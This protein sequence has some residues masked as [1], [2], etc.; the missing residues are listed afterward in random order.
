MKKSPKY[1]LALDLGTTSIGWAI[2]RLNNDTPPKPTAIIRSGVRI[3]TD[4][5]N[6]KDGSSLAVSR[7]DA[8]ST[9]RRRDRL[10]R[11]K[12][13]MMN[14]LIEYGFFPSD[15]LARK[16]Y[17]KLNPYQL[18]A[19]GLHRELSPAEFARAIFHL[20]QRRGFKSNRKTDSKDTESGVMKIAMTQTQQDI[21]ASGCTTAGEWL[22]QR[23]KKGEPT[24]ARYRVTKSKTATGKTTSHKA[25]DLYIDRQMIEDEFDALWQ[26]QSQYNPNLYSNKA[27]KDIKDTLLFQRPLKPVKAGRCTFI[28]EKE[29]APLALPSNQ[30]FRIYQEVNN[31]KIIHENYTEQPLTHE[32][33]DVIALELCRKPKLTFIGIN[34]LLNLPSNTH[35]NLQDE[36][37][38]ELKGNTTA[39]TL[40]KKEYFGL[41]WHN[42]TLEKQDE[43][44]SKLLEEESE[45]KLIEWLQ[46]HTDVDEKTASQIANVRLVDGYGSL[47]SEALGKILYALKTQYCVYSDAVQSAG[48]EH[49]SKLGFHYNP[50]EVED[51][52]DTSTGEIK[53]IFKSLPYYGKALNRYVAFGSGKSEDSDEKRYGKIAN[54]T[55]HIALNQ[56]QKLVNA[57]IKEYGRP[58]EIVIEIARDLKNSKKQKDQ[59]KKTQAFNKKRNERIQKEISELLNINTE[60]VKHSDIQKWILWEELASDP[61][62]RACP[63]TGHKIC[64]TKLLTSEVEIEHILPFSRTLDDSLNNKTVSLRLANRVKRNRTPYEAK[65]DFEKN[66]WLYDDILL[67]T[68]S[69][70]KAK[71]QRFAPNAMKQ[72]EGEQNFLARAL[73]DTQYISRITKEYLGL[74]CPGKGLGAHGVNAIPGKMTAK[75]RYH[76]GL[77]GILGHLGEKNREDH[78]HHAVDACVIG[79]T[80]NAL[81]QKFA[82][83]NKRAEDE[84]LNQLVKDVPLP[85]PTYRQHVQRAVEHIWVS[86][87][88]D[89]G[90]QGAMHN[91]TAYGLLGNGKVSTHKPS[92]TGRELKI[93]NLKVIEFSDP[94]PLKPNGEPRHGQLEDGTPKPYKG[95]KG[96]SN[97]CIEII[98]DEKGK[99]KGEVIST[100]EAYQAHKTLAQEY[101]KKNP[102]VP[103]KPDFLTLL[104]DAESLSGKPLVMRLF[105]DDTLILEHNSKKLIVR[106]CK[107]SK[108]GTLSLSELKEANVD[109]RTRKKELSYIFK[110]AGS[111]QKSNARL[112]RVSP[113]GVLHIIKQKE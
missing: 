35:Y 45:L 62:D 34:K 13:R 55:V 82:N 57:L 101:K 31:L 71:A 42:F 21:Q 96:D 49:H 83:A 106:I 12:K 43:I 85:W 15:S 52:I 95:Y 7:R 87:K 77:N 5:R 78:R 103:R 19:E 53:P 47:C 92:D 25:Y 69:M 89:H 48:F 108:D 2:L 61:A 74:I 36:K 63:F 73:T 22:W 23:H 38:K 110:T 46:G 75:L 41:D 59:I 104:N 16:Q 91:D 1:R 8:R 60:Q 97:Y 70:P 20:T 33:R 65:E 81:L 66:N 84:G 80:D 51:W 30:Q 56:I 27:Y 37:R 6:P 3:F 98:K 50:E 86:H 112:V 39:S 58:T 88:P 102:S 107:F 109:A 24:R 54:P 14:K 64:K 79:I 32:Q 68:K 111:L 67:R 4:G 11:R 105:K 93:E 94:K 72:Y 26:E 40:N 113:T 90:Y 29:R 44:V 17:E 9:R 100:F 99:W 28:P 76:F 10:I 18:R